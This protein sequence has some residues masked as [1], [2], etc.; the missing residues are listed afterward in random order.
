M[1][2]KMKWNHGRCNGRRW[3]L[4]PRWA[5]ETFRDPK[6]TILAPKMSPQSSQN[7][8]QDPSADTEN[9]TQANDA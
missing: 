1:V 4:R 9:T 3:T 8:D 6:A 7:G 5:R 2:P